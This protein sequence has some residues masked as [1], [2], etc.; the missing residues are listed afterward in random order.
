[1]I[2]QKVSLGFLNLSTSKKAPF[3]ANVID[4]LTANA[5]VFPA[6]PVTV[7]QLTT[8]NTALTLALKAMEQGGKQARANL[9]A[10]IA[11]WN[12]AFKSDAA[13]VSTVANGNVQTLLKS[14]YNPTKGQRQPVPVPGAC[15]NFHVVASKSTGIVN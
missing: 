5:T 1:M 9:D 11:A 6:L 8:V 3:G 15:A 10:A 7:A 4:L 13:Y 12:A 14:G 2:F